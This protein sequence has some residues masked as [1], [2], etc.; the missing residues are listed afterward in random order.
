MND[1]PEQALECHTKALGIARERGEL[2]HRGYALWAVGLDVWHAGDADRA[3]ELLKDGL[4]ITRR[5]QDPL[6]IFICLQALAWIAAERQESTRAAVIMGAASAHRHLIGSPPVFFP[7]L[8]VH[9]DDFNFSVERVLGKAPFETAQREGAAMPTDEAITY[10]LDEESGQTPVSARTGSQLTRRELQVADLIAQGMTNKEIA[11]RLVIS[12]RTADG[13][14]DHILAKLGFTSR[15]Q[16]A[17][18]VSEQ[19]NGISGQR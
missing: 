11:T 15:V 7:N 17:V 5:T 8:L 18:W 3:A 19:Q 4:R 9:H 13:H 14:V 1:D 10:A 6:M 16:I 12:R 2:I